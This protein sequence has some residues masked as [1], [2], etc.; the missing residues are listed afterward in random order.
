MKTVL[1]YPLLLLVDGH[2]LAFRSYYAFGKSRQGGLRTSTGIPTSVCFGFFKSLL[3][4][5]ASHKPDYLAIA[6]DL[7]QPTFRHEADENY[8]ADRTETPQDFIEDVENLKLLLQAFDLT[9]ITAPGYEADD[10]LGTLSYRGSQ[11]KYRVKILSGDQDLF[12]LIDIEKNISV[13]HLEPG[14]GSNPTEFLAEQVYQK[15]QI[16]PHQV[17]DY[18]ALC[19]DKSDNIPGVKGIGKTTAVKL[20]GEYGSLENIYAHIEDIKGATRKKLEEG[21]PDADHS[22]TLA[23][24]IQD[25]PL[26]VGLEDFKL[27]G[28][29]QAKIQP[30]LEHLQLQTFLDKVNQIQKQFKGNIQPK[31]PETSVDTEEDTSFFTRQETEIYQQQR[32]ANNPA[33]KIKL[34]LIQT[35]EDLKQLVAILQNHTDTNYP[36][37]WDTETTS[38]EPRKAELVGIG[39]CWGTAPTEVAYI[40]LNHTQGTNLDKA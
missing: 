34:R 2:S 11:E 13:L 5:M 22:Q 6:F 8:K 37:A 21:K 33:S 40:P 4:V 15:L 10:I 9:I 19:G 26:E 27:Q 1:E 28:F 29:D 16:Y 39:C 12:Q 14:K 25:V 35:P 30:I 7:K 38:L 17:I 3:D 20:L 24:I 23:R 31:T 32:I 18:K 36:V